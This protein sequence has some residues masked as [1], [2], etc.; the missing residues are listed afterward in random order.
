MTTRALVT[1]GAGF[2]GSHVC[3][4]LLAKGWTV[5]IIDDLSSGKRENVP[6]A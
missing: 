5:E 1:G 3:D 2:I 4:L 6:A